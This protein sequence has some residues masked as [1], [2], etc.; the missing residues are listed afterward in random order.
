[1][2]YSCWLEQWLNTHTRPKV[3]TSTATMY[4]HLIDDL[5]EHLPNLVQLDISVIDH[6]MLQDALNALASNYSKSSLQKFRSI[7]AMSFRHAMHNRM[8]TA[9]PCDD[10]ILPRD[11]SEKKV[12]ALTIEEQEDLEKAAQD[13]PLGHVVIFFLYSGLRCSE[14]A[15]LRWRDVDLRNK[16]IRIRDSKTEAGVRR[17]PLIPKTMEI[18]LSL[19]HGSQNDKVFKSPDGTDLNKDK[20]RTLAYRMREAAGLPNLTTH[21]YRH[22]FATRAV[23]RGMDINALSKILGHTDPFFTA[24]R[25]VHPCPDFLMDQMQNVFDNK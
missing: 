14:L 2:T 3:R 15:N 6:T 25:Y 10:L 9:Y 1:M 21:V 7:F 23:E 12:D 18:L 5:K 4:V 17:V 16:W 22:T 24:K 20:L 8:I 11:S 19:P 13:D